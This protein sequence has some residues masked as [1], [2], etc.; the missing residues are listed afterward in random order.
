MNGQYP[1]PA[2][3][4]FPERIR[5]AY[6]ALPAPDTDRLAYIEAQLCRQLRKPARR[7]T[8]P[9]WAWLLLGAG[10]AAAA[11]WG[12][13]VFRPDAEHSMEQRVMPP[14]M[15]DEKPALLPEEPDKTEAEPGT[16]RRSPVIY[17]RENF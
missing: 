9:W 8:V 17:Q 15:L 5:A 2:L 16:E 13:D 11:W 12:G 6:E 7:A 1:V 4:E 10:A 14:A 3:E